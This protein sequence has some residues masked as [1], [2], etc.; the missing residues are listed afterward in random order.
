MSFRY[1]YII[2]LIFSLQTV[3][4]AESVTSGSDYTI[5][6]EV[7]KGNNGTCNAKEGEITNAVNGIIASSQ[8]KNGS[9]MDSFKNAISQSVNTVMRS[10]GCELIDKATKLSSKQTINV[11]IGTV[12]VA[13]K[14]PFE[15]W[16]LKKKIVNPFPAICTIQPNKK[17]RLETRKSGTLKKLIGVAG[18]GGLSCK[19]M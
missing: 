17:I 16:E 5:I 19:I 4:Y 10:S 8:N 6:V 3:S 2:A 7:Y 12:I 14:D 9:F 13:Y 11:P 15:A 18:D 1:S